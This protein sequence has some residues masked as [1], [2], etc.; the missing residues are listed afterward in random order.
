MYA[1]I[2]DIDEVW[3][4]G[5][6]RAVEELAK[7]AARGGRGSAAAPLFELGEHP[8]EGGSVNVMSGKYGPYVKW[9]KVNATIPKDVEPEKVTMDMAV[10]LIVEKVP[11]KKKSAAKKKPAT[12]KAPA[13]K[14]AAKKKD[15]P[16]A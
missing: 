6:N 9:G 8:S 10:A 2:G 1:N 14:A 3:S 12:K 5:M 15:K 7:K 11:T 4:I 13:K 16:K